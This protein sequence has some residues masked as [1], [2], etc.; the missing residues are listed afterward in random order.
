MRSRDVSNVLTRRGD[1]ERE[2]S[3]IGIVWVVGA[4]LSLDGRE[5]KMATEVYGA[6]GKGAVKKSAIGG[7]DPI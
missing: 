1:Y 2:L 6:T 3:Q 4:D 7:I 5:G